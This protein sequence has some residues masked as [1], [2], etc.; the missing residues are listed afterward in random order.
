LRAAALDAR[1][2]LGGE[3]GRESEAGVVEALINP[4]EVLA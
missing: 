3:A 4:L 1:L 2:G